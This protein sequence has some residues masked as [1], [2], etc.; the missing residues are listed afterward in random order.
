[1]GGYKATISNPNTSEEAK[2]HAREQ[3]ESGVQEAGEQ[4]Q[5][6]REDFPQNPGNVIGGLKAT[7]A[8]V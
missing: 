1:M 6:A 4:A 2:Q 5:Q 7:I 8:C 3:L